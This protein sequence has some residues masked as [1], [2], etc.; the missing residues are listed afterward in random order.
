[1]CRPIL[2]VL[3]SYSHA[4]HQPELI[5][6]L[7]DSAAAPLL[8]A[9]DSAHNSK[10]TIVH[11]L[12]QGCRRALV[13]WGTVLRVRP[14]ISM[15]V[16]EIGWLFAAAASSSSARV[17]L[18]VAMQ[19]QACA[20]VQRGS[21]LAGTLLAEHERKLGLLRVQLGAP[22]PAR[23]KRHGRMAVRRHR[24]CSRHLDCALAW[25]S[26]GQRF[27]ACRTPRERAAACRAATF[28]APLLLLG[29]SEG[30]ACVAQRG[31]APRRRRQ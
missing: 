26:G 28:Y 4:A 18:E 25:S 23:H 24:R 9:A 20:G 7:H 22:A 10:W 2:A 13:R 1:M 17:E 3:R 27:T 6:R 31:A 19:L 12:R 15:A 21:F 29:V 5:P 11:F 14:I 16:Q 30:A 8:L